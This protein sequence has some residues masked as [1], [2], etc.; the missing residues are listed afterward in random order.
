MQGSRAAIVLLVVLLSSDVAANGRDWPRFRGEHA[1]VAADDPK[2]P[3]GWSRTENVVWQADIPGTGW[4]SPIV[5]GDHIFLTSVV[6][7]DGAEKPQPGLYSGGERPASPAIHRWMVYD[8]DFTT[9]KVRWEREVRRSPPLGPKHVKNTYATETPVTD[10]QHVYVYFG[11][12]GLFAFTMNG[13]PVW[14]TPIGANATR[15][16]WGTAASPALFGDRII[17]VNDNDTQSYIAA[18]D[19]RTGRQLWRIDRNEG[20]NWASPFV[21]EHERGTEIVTIGTRAV[22]SYDPDGKQ[23]WEL[24]GMSSITAPTPFARDGLLYM[25]SGFPGDARR[26]VFAVRP[27]ASGDISLKN[28]ETSNDSIAWFQPLLG[29][30]TTS[31]LMYGEYYYTLLDRGFLLCHDARTG[32][33]VYGRKRLI[34]GGFTA[35]PWAYNGKIFVMSEEGDTYVIQAG[36]EFKILGKN[37]LDEMTLATPA[38][39]SGSLI[40][41]TLSRLYRIS[42]ATTP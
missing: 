22:R 36:P 4:S 2:L 13:E 19:K 28:G 17:I 35:S 27:G 30:Y 7:D 40:V 18:F 10:G 37:S 16:G 11:G 5:S 23:L 14:S 6:S 3:D 29:S 42:A 41:R 31:A 15:S 24:T 34:A 33:E 9:G 25:S 20:T 38:I 12:V 26:P 21:W 1:G 32:R 39:A 8:I